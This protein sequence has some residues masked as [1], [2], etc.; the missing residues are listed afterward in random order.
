MWRFKPFSQNG[1]L[2]ELENGKVMMENW[3]LTLK[4]YTTRW[5]VPQNIQRSL[6]KT[7]HIQL[8]LNHTTVW[9]MHGAKAKAK[10]LD[11]YPSVDEI[12]QE[13]ARKSNTSLSI[14]AR[15]KETNHPIEEALIDQ[16]KEED[17]ELRLYISTFM[18][19]FHNLSKLKVHRLNIKRP[20]RQNKVSS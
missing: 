19:L 16:G 2:K 1:T 14:P 17:Y 11:Y 15:A 5:R 12:F 7:S 20:Y 4:V 18:W 9:Y 3:F 13:L 6:P 10:P 8:N